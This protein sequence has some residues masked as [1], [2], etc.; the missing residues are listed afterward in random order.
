MKSTFD[1]IDPRCE[2]VALSL[3]CTRFEAFGWVVLPE[4]GKGLLTAFTLASIVLVT[5]HSKKNLVNKER[6]SGNSP[7][8]VRTKIAVCVEHTFLNNFLNYQNHA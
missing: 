1:H 5:S 7:L 4:A 3:G 8:L 2:Q 6:A